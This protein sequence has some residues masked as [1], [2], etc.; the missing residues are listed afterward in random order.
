MT[1]SL[2]LTVRDILSRSAFHPKIGAMRFYV[3]VHLTFVRWQTVY[4]SEFFSGHLN[5]DV[6]VAQGSMRGTPMFILYV[7]DLERASKDSKFYLN[8]DDT[9][10]TITSM[11]LPSAIHNFK[12]R[13][14]NY[15]RKAKIKS[16]IMNAT[17][18]NFGVP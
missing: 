4:V 1:S 14:S 16:L 12:R 3:L 6:G 8:A 7:N 10:A 9:S 15:N 5:V 11:N 2:I 18:S 13:T 17:K